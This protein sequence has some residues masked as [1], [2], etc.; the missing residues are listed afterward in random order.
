M[1]DAATGKLLSAKNIVPVSWASHIDL[2]TGRP[3][4]LPGARY[5]EHP[6]EQVILSP[7]VYGAHNWQAMSYS[8][9]TGLV[10]IPASVLPTKIGLTHD[11]SAIG[12]DV[13]MDWSER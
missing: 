12:G 9:N 8:P 7:G 6:G 13:Y 1:I 4:E 3:V 5:Y 2:K 11:S 10:Y